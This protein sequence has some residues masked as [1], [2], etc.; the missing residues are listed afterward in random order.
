MSA[1]L[2]WAI[3]HHL[4]ILTVAG[5]LVAELFLVHTAPA[6]ATIRLLAR[7]DAGFGLAAAATLAAGFGRVFL[8]I[9]PHE[10]YLE[11]PV[12]WAKVAAFAGVGL[13][14]IGPT[15]RFLK[16]RRAIAA[17]GNFAPAMPDVVRVRRFLW[18]ETLLFLTIPVFAALM[19]RGY[20]L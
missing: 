3:A 14:S 9:R 2:G 17:D 15:L 10:F 5:L 7:L 6:P 18:G 4:G 8:G 19:A 16:W 12:F 20:G 1:D 11:N 13:L